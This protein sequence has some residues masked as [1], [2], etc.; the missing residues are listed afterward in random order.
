MATAGM[1]A[2]RLPA[3]CCA[4]GTMRVGER[5]RTLVMVLLA[6]LTLSLAAPVYGQDPAPTASATTG[7]QSDAAAKVVEDAPKKEEEKSALASFNGFMFKTL[8]F[9]IT[10]G[11]VTIDEV[12]REGHPVIDEATGQPKQ[13]TISFPFLVLVLV[14]GAMFFT[15][16]YR[17]INLRAFRHA[18][19]IVRGIYD[20]PEDEGEISHW[21]ALSSALSATVG[22]GNIAGVALAIVKGGPGAVVWMMIIAVFGMTAKFSSCTLALMYRKVNDDDTISG[23]PMYY[24]DL[25]L[26]EMGSG[27]GAFGKVLAVVYAFMIMG[28]ALGGGN[29]FQANQ[30]VE[31]LTNSFDLGENAKWYIGVVMAILVGAV[32]LGGIKRIGAATSKIVPAMC[33]LYIVAS[34]LVILVNITKLPEAIGLMFSMAFNKNAFFGGLMGVLVIGVQRAAFSNEAGLGSAAVAHAAAKTNEPVREGMVAMLGPFIDTIMVCFMTAM[35]VIITGQWNAPEVINA[36]GLQGASVTSGAFATVFSWFPWVLS[37]CIALFA[38]STM[39][40]WCY[41]GER[42]WIY[43]LDHFDGMGLKTVIVFRIVFVC[44]VVVGATQPLSDVLDFS[45]IMILSMAFP[46]IIGSVLLAP[47]I[48]PLVNDYWD[49]FK[50]GNMQTFDPK[51]KKAT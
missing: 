33:G 24:L 2:T 40:A 38:Y 14:L 44:A 26:K 1:Q 25:G 11:A 28:G 36:T 48:L 9:D 51:T 27:W 30:T 8:F 32:I 29:M 6:A 4:A 21:Q 46:N 3:D 19:D 15:F 20:D 7:E 18:I 43:L 49:R 5:M 41:Y 34:L 47:K 35:V 13:K 17:F 45:D 50:S 37:V 39:I 42:G 16:Y 22:L 12:D 31:Q 10:G 23:G